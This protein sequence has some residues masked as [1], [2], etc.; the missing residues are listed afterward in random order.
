MDSPS[1]A[2]IGVV[3]MGLGS[4]IVYGAYKNVSV[5]GK[6]GILGATIANGAIPDVGSLP[7]LFGEQGIG[8]LGETT[9]GNAEDAIAKI[10]KSD[11][12]LAAS[13][14]GELTRWSMTGS[15]VGGSARLKALIEQARN[16]G[17]GKEADTIE[18]YVN[19]SNRN[20]VAPT[21]PPQNTQQI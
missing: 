12:A 8:K 11:P 6:N 2:L 16:K 5:F 18:V 7:H 19:D 3:G 9:L 17:F 4:L 14:T 10:A 20:P 1:S 13:L 15:P 21:P